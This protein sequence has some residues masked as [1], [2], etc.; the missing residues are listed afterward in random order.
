MFASTVSTFV[1]VASLGVTTTRRSLD[2]QSDIISSRGSVRP[3]GL[4]CIRVARLARTRT[5]HRNRVQ[6]K[7]QATPRPGSTIKTKITTT[8]QAAPP[9]A[10]TLLKENKFAIGA[11]ALIAAWAFFRF[12]P[13]GSVDAL[14]RRGVGLGKERGVDAD[15]FY[16]GMMKNV[17]TAAFPELTDEQISAARARRR[18]ESFRK[19]D[20]SPDSLYDQ[21]EIPENHPWAT[22][23]Q[24]SKEDEEER[25]A[26]IA[27]QN[28]RR[29]RAGLDMGTD[30]DDIDA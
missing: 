27:A 8:I 13:K 24:V 9:S 29:R 10:E 20:G 21:V 5:T 17:R 14:A 28:R 18:Q 11:V 1:P 22:A 3:A 15:T 16:K 25:Q 7:C 30:M 19:E 23:K 4:S 6:V 2:L 26:N 12:K